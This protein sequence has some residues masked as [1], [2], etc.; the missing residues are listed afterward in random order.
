[1]SQLAPFEP[2]IEFELLSKYMA[3]RCAA[4]RS[5]G[6]LSWVMHASVQAGERSPLLAAEWAQNQTIGHRARIMRTLNLTSDE[7][8]L[9]AL[10]ADL[11]PF[12]S[13]AINMSGSLEQSLE[14]V[15][16]TIGVDPVF[17]LLDPLRDGGVKLD[18]LARLLSRRGRQTEMLAHLDR[19]SLRELRE[20]RTREHIDEVIGSSLW[21][22]LCEDSSPERS[23]ARVSALY[24]ASLQRCGY[25]FARE[26]PLR[27]DC[28]QQAASR[29]VFASRS[30]LSVASMSDLV[31]RY[32]RA[33]DDPPK[34]DISELSAR[35]YELGGRL[36]SA[37]TDRL[38]QGLCPQLFGE[39]Q[40]TDYRKAIRG[41]VQRGAIA[42]SNHDGSD[43]AEALTFNGAPQMALFDSTPLLASAAGD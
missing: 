8:T 10:E 23:L 26:I 25:A 37:S 40:N 34:R 13:V 4:W 3:A 17:V 12:S 38:I 16:Q 33:H 36:G 14:R 18:S 6:H 19:D 20:T 41:L 27:G 15:V 39:F 24:R 43:D 35:V 29:L 1:M 28:D 31:C 22:S 42:R 21:R 2:L 9:E 5:A 30:R 11:S 32:R 7:Q